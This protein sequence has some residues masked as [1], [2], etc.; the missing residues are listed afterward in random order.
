M[1]E[2]FRIPFIV[3]AGSGG[4]RI[5]S[6]LNINSV[7]VAVNSSWK[8]LEDLPNDVV[9]VRAGEG[10]G[11]GMD[12]RMG[13]KHYKMRRD[14]FKNILESIM[15]DRNLGRDEVD[16]IPVVV[17]AGFGFGSGSGPY[18][19]E[20]LKKWFPKSVILAFVTKPF[21][22]E[23]LRTYW[24]AWNCVKKIMDKTGTI[25]IDNEY[26]ASITGKE[27]SVLDVLKTVNEYVS[28]CI[29]TFIN[30]AA[31]RNVLAG[32]DRTDVGRI[33][34]KGFIRLFTTSIN[35]FTEPELSKIYN[36]TSTL[37]PLEYRFEGKNIEMAIFIQ[38]P[39]TPSMDIPEKIVKL[40]KE[41]FKIDI[42]S[43][44]TMIA[45]G[46]ER[47]RVS[48]LAGGWGEEYRTWWEDVSQ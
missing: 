23:G 41:A 15:K 8:D 19:V 45:I 36:S 18:I 25:I 1:V 6:K 17:T 38:A 11:S 47:I 4:C 26:V 28:R 31:S 37:T 30:V 40:A 33:A 46:G 44:K 32:I 2:H 43:A 7:K 10:K 48:V 12:P 35:D 39:K 5:V 42:L 22:F 34:R 9:K 20:D 21:S 13:E 14:E 24:N 27:R 16:L 3:G 29:G